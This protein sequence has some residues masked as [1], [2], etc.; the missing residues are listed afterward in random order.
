MINLIPNQ[1]KKKMTKDFYIRLLSLCFIMLSTC[2]F[3]ASLLLLPSYF[4]SSYKNNTAK[5]KLGMQNS[6]EIPTFNKEASAIIEDINSKMNIL[7][8]SNKSKFLVSEKIIQNILLKKPQN[9]QIT[10]VSYDDH[11]TAGKKI[12]IS[13]VALSRDALLS[14][15]KSLEDSSMFKTID[16]PISNFVKGAN[17]QFYLTLVPA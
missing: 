14:F 7:E 4:F 13:G 17:I 8:K 16:L 15:R 3:L 10:Q 11:V 6:G 2:I 12:S 9:I 5:D 1:E